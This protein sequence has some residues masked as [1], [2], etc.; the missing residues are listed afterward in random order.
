MLRTKG[1]SQRGWGLPSFLFETDKLEVLLSDSIFFLLCFFY[2]FHA[3]SV[4]IAFPSRHPPTPRAKTGCGGI[5]APA[6]GAGGVWERPTR[7][8][9]DAL[10]FG[11]GG[12]ACGQRPRISG[13]MFFMQISID[14]HFAGFHAQT[15]CESNMTTIF[16]FHNFLMMSTRT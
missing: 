1:G 6:V 7:P 12:L 16:F 10:P 2:S 9:G 11:C 13:G 4:S 14:R 3:H 5:G 8:L 15:G